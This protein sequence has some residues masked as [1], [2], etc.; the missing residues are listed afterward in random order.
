M[1]PFCWW[2]PS[3]T[4]VLARTLISGHRTDSMLAPAVGDDVKGQASM[5]L[6]AVAIPLAFVDRWLAVGLFVLVMVM[7]LVPDRRIEDTLRR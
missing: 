6:Y 2:L 7:W 5:V 4:I 3:P 1:G